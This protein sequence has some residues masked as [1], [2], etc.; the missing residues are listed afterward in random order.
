[1]I[2][3][4][5]GPTASGKST[6]ARMLAHKLGYYY[7]YSGLMFRAVAYVLKYHYGYT[8][9]QFEH[10]RLED[11]T[12]LLDSKRFVYSYDNTHNERIFFDGVDITPHLKAGNMD[13]H[14]SIV[15]RHEGVREQLMELQRAIARSN[16][17]IIDGRDSG[18]V[19]FPYADYKFYV[20]AS[21]QER[22][23]R[24]LKQ[25]QSYGSTISLPEARAFIHERDERDTKRA[26]APLVIPK[27]AYVIDTTYQ[28]PQEAI[29][30]MCAIIDDNSVS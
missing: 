29:A 28:T 10:P 15:S 18:S 26:I 13:Q 5:D 1:M 9:T 4:I 12:H 3:T 17:V 7:L 20:T 24:W 8:E 22:A 25:Q 27:G 11:I 23:R 6:L 19:V 2:I 14:A 30:A 21:E 16:N